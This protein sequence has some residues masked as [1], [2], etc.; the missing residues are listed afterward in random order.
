MNKPINFTDKQIN[1][2]VK[3][4]VFDLQPCNDEE[5]RATWPHR[6]RNVAYEAQKVLMKRYECQT[7]AFYISQRTEDL[8]YF[9][10]DK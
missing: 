8:K 4:T 7:G 2:V 10:L 6:Y 1:E 3:K 9:G 5:V